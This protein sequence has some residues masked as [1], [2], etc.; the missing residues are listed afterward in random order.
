MNFRAFLYFQSNFSYSRPFDQTD[1]SL[2]F[3]D[4][5]TVSQR[6]TPAKYAT[7]HV[8][9]TI[10]SGQL[11]KIV[12][13]YPLDGQ[14]A[15]VELCDLQSFLRYDDELQE[16][17]EFPGPLIKGVTHKKTIIE[18][19]ENKI[20]NVAYNGDI[21]DVESYILMWELLILLLRQN[22]VRSTTMSCNSVFT[23][24]FSF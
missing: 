18:Y 20:K 17:T 8:K 24:Y 11:V 2:L 14:P 9:A 7:A 21:V 13:S 3:E 10:N 12:P 23:F 16:L 19:C 6:L 5:T 15:S 22:G 1:S 4:Q